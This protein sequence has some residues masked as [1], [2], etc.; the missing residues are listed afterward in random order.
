MTLLERLADVTERVLANARTP[1]HWQSSIYRGKTTFW[2][3][4]YSANMNGWNR[5]L[6]GDDFASFK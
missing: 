5:R 4:T 2:V 3:C 1:A 6:L